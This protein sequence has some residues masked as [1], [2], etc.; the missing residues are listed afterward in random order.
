[1]AVAN[2]QVP[3]IGHKMTVRVSKWPSSMISSAILIVN[4]NFISFFSV[5]VVGT[6]R[7]SFL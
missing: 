1:M 4:A 2:G 3:V 7:A 5:V 6:L